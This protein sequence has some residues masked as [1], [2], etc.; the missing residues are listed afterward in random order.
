MPKSAPRRAHGNAPASA[1]RLLYLSAAD[2]GDAAVSQ[3]L[4]GL[5]NQLVVATAS[6]L[7]EALAELRKTDSDYR[8]LVISPA[9]TENHVLTAI[10]AVRR[11]RVTVSILPV[12]RDQAQADV[13]VNGGASDVLAMS[14]DLLVNP[15]ETI[16]SVTNT[17]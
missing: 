3:Q 15:L 5:S 16:A 4:A 13:L 10:G 9:L 2:E 14:G 12:L 17:P 11:Q 8:A 7:G 1:V 6:S